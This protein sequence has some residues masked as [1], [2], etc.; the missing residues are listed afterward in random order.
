M[1]DSYREATTP[2]EARDEVRNAARNGQLDPELVE[3][4]IGLL[5]REG[6]AYG[7]NT[8]FD[9]ELDFE[10]RVDRMATPGDGY[11]RGRP[12]AKESPQV[13]GGRASAGHAAMSRPRAR[14]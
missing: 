12:T 7:Q 10:T 11:P 1:G 9:A 2:A 8:D 13:E 4:F 6:P 5:E 14:S 3:A